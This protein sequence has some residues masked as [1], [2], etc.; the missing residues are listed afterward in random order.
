MPGSFPLSADAVYGQRVEGFYRAGAW[1]TGLLVDH[2]D[3]W[4][5]AEPDAIYLYEGNAT[6][7]V[8]ELRAR[9]E[10]LARRL[11]VLGLGLGDRIAVQLPNWHEIVVVFLAAQRLGAIMVPIMPIYRDH[12]VG[13]VLQ[14]SGASVLVTTPTYRDFS[15]RDMVSRLRPRLPALR[16][17]LY[18]RPASRLA[19]A[20]LRLDFPIGAEP[21]SSTLPPP[22]SPDEPSLMVF[23]SGT[24]AGAKGC[25][26]TW[27]TFAFSCRGIA[28]ECDFR[29]GDVELVPSPV[30]HTTGLIGALKPLMYRGRACLMLAWDP[31]EALGL[32]RRHRCTHV[33]A[34][35]VFAQTL[36]DAFD[37][38]T[39]DAGSLR[40][41]L[42]GGAPVP[43]SL[44]RRFSER[45]GG[46]RM[47][48]MYGQTEIVNGSLA[49]PADPAA[50]VSS[51]DGSPLRGVELRIVDAAGRDVAR[52]AEGEILYRGPGGMLGYWGNPEAT[53]RV[54]LA[55]GW[56]RTGDCGYL[57]P[58]GYLRVTG[59]VKEMVIRGGMNISVLEIEELIRSHPQVKDVAVL[60]IPDESLGE[61]LGAAVVASGDLDP[62]EL[63]RYLS[64][65]Q[66]VAKQKLPEVLYFMRELPRTATGKVQRFRI[67]ENLISVKAAP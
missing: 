66:R 59:R 64:E 32:I 43:E 55:D 7:R 40:Y 62:P 2:L 41:F 5:A 39:H 23:T 18:A 30:T 44:V 35:T 47:L 4:A 67:L 11:H 46:P 1:R 9:S 31:A 29:P 27:N 50:R 37:P 56:R 60:G 6:L 58:D 61:R 57:D 28:Q 33:M 21:R 36:L 12:E 34:A 19:R 17:V 49:R 52:G 24:E 45:L 48:T 13:H 8:G 42:C 26:H 15:Y 63:L 10:A 22:P 38:A 51:S 25:V 14:V 54:I 65:E 16:H 3:Q 20:D 53:A